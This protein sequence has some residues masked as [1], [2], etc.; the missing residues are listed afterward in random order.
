MERAVFR[1]AGC[2][3]TGLLMLRRLTAVMPAVIC[4]LLCSR[5]VH[6][7]TS[8]SV[9][10]IS[11]EAKDAPLERVLHMIE[12]QSGFTFL[13]NDKILKIA[14]RV[15]IKVSNIPLQDALAT[16]FREQPLTWHIID[17][18]IV[19]KER[20]EKKSVA[21]NGAGSN[22]NVFLA[23][24]GVVTDENGNPL[25]G[26]SVMVKDKSKGT[27]TNHRGEFALTGVNTGDVLVLTSVGY[28]RKEVTIGSETN[29]RIQLKVAIGNLDEVQVIAYGVTSQRMSTGNISSVKA[30]EIE[31]QPVN[32]PLL[33]LQG[34]V[35]GLMVM[36]STGVPGGGII[37]RIQGQNSLSR[38][39]DPLY[40]IDG[41]P[42]VSQLPPDLSG[43]AGG[44]LGNNGNQNPF[45]STGGGNP[46]SFINPGDIESIEILK[47]ADAT[48]I[49]GSRA[50][51][52][53]ILITTRKGVA[54]KTSVTPQFEQGWGRATRYLDV[55]NR[56]QYLE[57]RNEAKLNDNMPVLPTDYDLNGTWDTTRD[58]DW[59]KELLGGT[60][61]YTD[62]R[63][64]VTGGNQNTRF[65]VAPGYHRE[66]TVFPGDLQ[67]EKASVN[68]NLNHT[69]PDK[70]FLLQLSTLYM[71]DNNRLINQD[72][73]QTAVS[74]APVAPPLH[75]ADGTLNW[76]PDAGGNASWFN[77][78]AYL[79]R[80]YNK[81][82]YNL[83]SSALLS[84]QLLPGLDIK[85]NLGYTSLTSDEW[86]LRPSVGNAPE[87]RPFTERISIFGNAD[88]RSWIAEPQLVYK[89]NLG[90]A[91]L[92]LLAG[93]T[94][95]EISTNAQQEV[96]IGFNSDLVMK[97]IRAATSTFYAENLI[98]EYK[99]SALFGRIN[100]NWN[101]KYIVNV[102]GRRDGSTRFGDENRFHNFG[103]V[104]GAWIFS[105]ERIFEKINHVFS[106]GKV[107]ASY[108]TTGNDQI[109]DY[110]FMPLYNVVTTDVP[111]QHA[112]GLLP[113]GLANP[114]LQWEETKKLQFG[115]DLG[116]W[117]D[118][119]LINAG[120]YH[121]RSSNQLLSY[122]LP[123]MTG[124]GSVQRNLP[125]TIRNTGF[126]FSV[127]ATIFSTKQFAWNTSF[128][129]TIP[130]NKL[131]AFPDLEKSTYANQYV[132]GEPV[133]GTTR[134]LDLVGVDP[135]S[136]IFV[137]LDKSGMFTSGPVIPDDYT[138]LNV[139]APELF[140]GW[141]HTFRAGT[142]E[143]GFLLQFVDQD[144]PGYAY[145]NRPGHFVSFNQE[146]VRANQPVTVMDRWQKP[147]DEA[148]FQKFSSAYRVDVLL[149]YV[150]A[151]NLSDGRFSDASFIRLKNAFL[152]WNIPAAWTGA[153]RMQQASLYIQGQNLLTITD[154]TGMD[155]ESQ[156]IINLPP[157]R[158]IT[159]G[160]RLTL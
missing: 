137:F 151:S 46:L 97:D 111:Y 108:G 157:L 132:I 8:K 139:G 144:G 37:V 71:V 100:F 145:G 81:K 83:I 19:I 155:P 61:Q 72:L 142:F 122:T 52:G 44:I 152:S 58:V 141:Q 133:Q 78:L 50:A 126:E 57:M 117:G 130:E 21:V 79:E 65:L 25:S 4:C 87:L 154:Y 59:Q 140:G 85:A 56:Q 86:E 113:A 156:S 125:A 31:K 47:D 13:Y 42:Y 66:T 98:T 54:G 150:Y 92:E 17:K 114:Y 160:A 101:N 127:S 147:G 110:Q 28:E 121:N 95:Q 91:R 107:R 34:R 76:A 116:F 153:V 136:G 16:T 149:P 77:P 20:D 80:K 143:F 22:G 75:N 135:A 3:P 45:S 148:F 27:R 109:G 93:A 2:H 53:A 119:L 158:I 134:A 48:A 23:I 112:T 102:T 35:P 60:A 6:A 11:I 124:F 14:R 70:K 39:A 49:Y 33:A 5:P 68:I 55:L 41:V 64:S 40:V 74:L 73:T 9:Q 38:G 69:S 105:N 7:H 15:T 82:V 62:A 159:I 118:R 88:S 1:E 103:S 106:Y 128:N 129:L 120:Y 24:A 10:H 131:V 18:V 115:L 36:Q 90:K 123:A 26:V 32:N 84:Y 30:R 104:G 146:S 63:I 29:L 43:R 51:A 96:A 89:M 94:F 138:K 67:D 99:Y 12:R